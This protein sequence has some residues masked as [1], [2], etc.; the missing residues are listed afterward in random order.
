MWLPSQI[1]YGQLHS[2][3]VARESQLC[4][5]RRIGIEARAVDEPL[6]ANPARSLRCSRV[7]KTD[8][9]EDRDA[10]TSA[11]HGSAWPVRK[12]PW[13]GSRMSAVD[14]CDLRLQGQWNSRDNTS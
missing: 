6:E 10:K 8:R 14:S 11:T 5:G 12:A 3:G 13:R 1:R 9:P 7:R 4:R 2:A